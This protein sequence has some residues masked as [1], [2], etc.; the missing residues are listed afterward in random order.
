VDTNVHVAMPGTAIDYARYEDRLTDLAI[1]GAQLHLKYGVTSVRDSY[2]T[3]MPLLAA[4]DKINSGKAIGA[5]LFV[6]GNIIGWGGTF[7]KAFR[8][9]VPES[10]YEER[11]DDEI[12]QGAGELMPWFSPDSLRVIVNRY[13][14][15]G[16]DFV[17]IGVTAH[18]QTD[19]AL[20]FSPRQMNAMVD[21]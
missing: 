4:R 6:A 1:E 19:P 3:M 17:K 14:D 18:P 2:G 21:A 8:G 12:T 16:V 10:Y 13:I 7:S 20:V 15:K 11:I 5:R 9:R